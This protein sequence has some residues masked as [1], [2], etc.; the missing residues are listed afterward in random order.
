ML[1]LLIIVSACTNPASE[2]SSHYQATPEL[3][4]KIEQEVQGIS[5]SLELQEYLENI[6]QLDQQYR[7]EEKDILQEFG[8]DSDEH[9][10][11][12][13]KIN[14]TDAENYFRIEA[15][16]NEYGYPNLDSV[17]QQ[18]ATTPWIVIHHSPFYEHRV[19]HFQ[20]IYEGYLNGN[21]DEDAMGLFLD[22]M[23]LMKFNEMF[24]MPSPYRMNTKI[25]TLIKVLEL[26]KIVVA[27]RR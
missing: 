5:N 7:T 24:D 4:N 27:N 2:L 1:T 21:L 3:L 26:E 17:G 23:H 13:K 18:A 8:H 10:E 15:I 9:Q 19:K 25:D 11:I 6:G 16:L 20:T 14:K 22:R 12:W